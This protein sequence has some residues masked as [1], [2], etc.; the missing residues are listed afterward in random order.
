MLNN[1]KAKNI[2]DLENQ[3]IKLATERQTFFNYKFDMERTI[4]EK[5][6]ILEEKDL[7]VSMMKDQLKIL[8]DE[9]EEMKKAQKNSITLLPRGV[10][11]K[12]RGGGK[13]RL[14]K[15]VKKEYPKILASFLL[16]IMIQTCFTGPIQFVVLFLS[17]LVGEGILKLAK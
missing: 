12:I 1:G 7:Q 14:G 8:V 5:T 2:L 11:K 15:F 3:I 16:P 13:T 10:V 17:V 4:Q 9:I 6:E